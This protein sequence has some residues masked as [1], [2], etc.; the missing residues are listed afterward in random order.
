MHGT[1]LSASAVAGREAMCPRAVGPDA[2]CLTDY[3][4]RAGLATPASAI[5][6]ASE[7]IIANTGHKGAGM[8]AAASFEDRYLFH[9][10]RL[11]LRCQG[12]SKS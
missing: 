11:R 6:G 12:R 7:R 10:Q 3:S 2:A 4:L 9:A 5:T 8:A 1:H